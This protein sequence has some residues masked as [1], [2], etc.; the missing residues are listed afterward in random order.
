MDV[1]LGQHNPNGGTTENEM[2]TA[3]YF[4]YIFTASTTTHLQH[5]FSRFS[6][7]GGMVGCRIPPRAKRSVGP[8]GRKIGV[9]SGS[10]RC[11]VFMVWLGY[12]AIVVPPPPRLDSGFYSGRFWG[13]GWGVGLVEWR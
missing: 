11:F 7:R 6:I 12:L 2:N 10:G 9:Y 1:R 5:I 4:W 3:Y 8:T 13:T